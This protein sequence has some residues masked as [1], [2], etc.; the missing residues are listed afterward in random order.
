[1]FST[2][3]SALAT[4][5]ILPRRELVT[6]AAPTS[7]SL[8]PSSPRGLRARDRAVATEM[9]RLP[10]AVGGETLRFLAARD[11]GREMGS[12]LA[13]SS[14]AG[15]RRGR[16]GEFASGAGTTSSATRT[17]TAMLFSKFSYRAIKVL[18]DLSS[19]LTPWPS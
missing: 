17:W 19:K 15:A 1:M 16:W 5:S 10:G 8:S 7:L 3:I 13:A 11:D 2:L 9:L 6:E 4:M 12:A 18:P 14:K